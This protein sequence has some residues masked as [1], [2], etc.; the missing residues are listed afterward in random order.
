MER[1]RH[2]SL[3]TLAGRFLV[4]QLRVLRPAVGDAGALVV[5][6]SQAGSRSFGQVMQR[7]PPRPRPSS[8]PA[9]VTTSMPCSRSMVLVAALRS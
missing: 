5:R 6:G 8:L 9:M 1:S 2:P 4:A 3:L 7:G